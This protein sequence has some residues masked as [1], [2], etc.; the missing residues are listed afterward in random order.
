MPRTMRINP[1]SAVDFMKSQLCG[2][3]HTDSSGLRWNPA[4]RHP[5]Q[6]N[7]CEFK[8]RDCASEEEL[9][10]LTRFTIYL[11]RMTM[12]HRPILIIPL[13]A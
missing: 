10:N 11:N 2:L 9:V 5:V 3:G 6:K 4:L 12:T 7:R 13:Q 8:M 1:T